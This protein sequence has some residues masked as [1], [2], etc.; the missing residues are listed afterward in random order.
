L[1]WMKIA[2]TPIQ[3]LSLRI[4][5]DMESREK[6]INR[7]LKKHLKG[8]ASSTLETLAKRLGVLPYE[9]V[10]LTTDIGIALATTNLRGAVEMLRGAPEV[11]RLIDSS[12]M[13]IWGEI[14]KRLSATSAESAITFFQTSAAV[15][16]TVDEE[17]RSPV[18]RLVNKQA[19]LSAS[20]A[21]ETFKSAPGI[22]ASIADNESIAQILTI[23]LELARHSVKHSNDLFAASPQV[24]SQMR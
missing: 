24:V 20:T 14:G 11:S 3:R 15:L 13:R 22:I 21:M 12:D 8:I 5:T 7:K 6:E 18:L 19:A 10:L 23:C 9:R 17:M 2:P 1:F 4:N 16:D